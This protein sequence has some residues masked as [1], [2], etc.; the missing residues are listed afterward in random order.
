M[1]T[2]AWDNVCNH[3]CMSF[4]MHRHHLDQADKR[5]HHCWKQRRPGRPSLQHGFPTLV[6]GLA[7]EWLYLASQ[8][9]TDLDISEVAK[10]LGLDEW[11]AASTLL[12][13]EQR[14]AADQDY[15][16]A[17]TEFLDSLDDRRE[18]SRAYDR[19]MTYEE[20]GNELGLSW[21]RVQQIEAKALAKLR[22]SGLLKELMKGLLA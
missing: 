1:R 4:G 13:A 19:A 11:D 14:L 9:A 10:L 8:R 7:L 17:F 22:K 21:Q 16:V 12:D 6:A 15:A 3:V 2:T 5:R 20:I 18:Q